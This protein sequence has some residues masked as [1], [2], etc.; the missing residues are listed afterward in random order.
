MAPSEDDSRLTGVSK[1]PPAE[2]LDVSSAS[3][4]SAINADAGANPGGKAVAAASGG[5]AVG[6][7]LFVIVTRNGGSEELSLAEYIDRIDASINALLPDKLRTE[8]NRHPQPFSCELLIS[9][10]SKLGMPIKVIVQIIANLESE[11]NGVIDDPH[12]VSTA[13]L[14]KAVSRAIFKIEGSPSSTDSIDRWGDAYIRRYGNPESPIRVLHEDG[15]EDDLVH[16]FIRD[17]LIPHVI[18]RIF[19]RPYPSMRE[20]MRRKDWRRME[21]EILNAV[22]GLNV[23]SIRYK[24]L[25]NMAH[26]LAVQPPHPWLVE[27]SF[28]DRTTEYDMERARHH[29]KRM[30][31][32]ADRGDHDEAKHSVIECVHHSCSAILA[33]YGAFLGVGHLAPLHNLINVLKMPT[34]DGN[35]V[36][37]EF[38]RIRQIAGDLG[39]QDRDPEYLLRRLNR[40]AKLVPSVKR[41]NLPHVINNAEEVW[42]VGRQLIERRQQLDGEVRKPR[43]ALGDFGG[44]AI[45]IIV[46]EI[47]KRIPGFKVDSIEGDSLAF[48]VRHSIDT[49][50][51]RDM[52]S[53]ILVVPVRKSGVLG[54][55]DLGRVLEWAIDTA[56]REFFCNML[57]FVVPEDYEPELADEIQISAQDEL[58]TRMLRLRDLKR[59]PN[60]N[61]RVSL[62]EEI[63]AR[64]L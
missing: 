29:A 13:H 54:A 44:Q 45:R 34:D 9:S 26:D 56:H 42:R 60:S 11:L 30:R 19:D 37:W 20:H 36:L 31:Q 14:R 33:F 62:L 48:W 49:G 41:S 1:T 5:V 16:V 43:I 21:Q 4:V 61:D 32:A 25:L 64:K 47:L 3:G 10:L 52:K 18:E 50:V 24:T 39:A 38:S 22:K 6:E 35:V 8:P 40:L 57:V 46:S 58:C 63:L 55:S 53:K 12:N 59:I 7:N 15:S 2:A 27:K 51:F 23:Y 28:I 17:T